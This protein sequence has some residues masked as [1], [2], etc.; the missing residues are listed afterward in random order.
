M[1]VRKHNDEANLLRRRL[2]FLEQYDELVRDHIQ[3][4]EL[5][6]D[7]PSRKFAENY[8]S[9]LQPIDVVQGLKQIYGQKLKG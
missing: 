9:V 8:K 1:F 2:D 3:Y 6:P 7:G 4:D 5:L